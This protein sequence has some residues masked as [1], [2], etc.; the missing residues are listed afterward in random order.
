LKFIITTL[1]KKKTMWPKHGYEKKTKKTTTLN[2]GVKKGRQRK[3]QSGQ[4]YF[5]DGPLGV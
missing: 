3:K 1:A 4:N 5:K 2:E